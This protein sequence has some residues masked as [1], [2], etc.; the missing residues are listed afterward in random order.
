MCLC[1]Q[2]CS[3][4]SNCSVCLFR[5]VVDYDAAAV[6]STA[7]TRAARLVLTFVDEVFE[8]VTAQ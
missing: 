5:I 4:A 7:I 6:C 2:D 3:S 8:L 1:L